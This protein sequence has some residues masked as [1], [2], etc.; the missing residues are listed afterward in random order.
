MLSLM[1]L[2]RAL[3]SVSRGREVRVVHGGREEVEEEGEEGSGGGRR[4]DGSNRKGERKIRTE[5]GVKRMWRKVGENKEECIFFNHQVASGSL[6]KASHKEKYECR[7]CM[8]AKGCA[9]PA[10][11]T[12]SPSLLSAALLHF[13]CRANFM[14]AGHSSG[15]APHDGL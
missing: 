4:G 3:Y 2:I 12:P 10:I 9:H 5:M 8:E 1:P 13:S 11:L 7:Q 6:Y 14:T 15:V